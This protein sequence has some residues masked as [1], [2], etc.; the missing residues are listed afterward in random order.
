M[1]F[2]RYNIIEEEDLRVAV[3]RLE[4]GASAELGDPFGQDLDKVSTEEGA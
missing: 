1:M 4:E 3:R 2:E